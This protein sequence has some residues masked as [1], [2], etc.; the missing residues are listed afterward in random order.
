VH[1]LENCKAIFAEISSIPKGGIRMAMSRWDPFRDMFALS[2]AMD[3]LL[4]SAFIPAPRMGRYLRQAPGIAWD[5]A[6][7]DE[8]YIVRAVLPGIN[9]NDLDIEVNNQSLT[10]R[11]EFKEQAIPEGAR[12]YLRELGTGRFERSMQFPLPLNADAVEARYENGILT[13]RLPKAEAVK[14]RR[15]TVQ[16]QPRQIEAQATPVQGEQQAGV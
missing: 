4:N 12:Y 9:A 6:E 7:E 5:V 11:G 10:I 1:H 15:I 8:A 16:G 2:T 14:P 13:L 3:Q